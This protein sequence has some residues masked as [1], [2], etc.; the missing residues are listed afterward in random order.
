MYE[1]AH[2]RLGGDELGTFVAHSQPIG[3][4]SYR[5]RCA[6]WKLCRQNGPRGMLN[7]LQHVLAHEA[8]FVRTPLSPRFCSRL[9]FF[10]ARSRLVTVAR[11][12]LCA[13]ESRMPVPQRVVRS[14]RMHH[15]GEY[16]RHFTPSGAM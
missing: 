14:V 16:K 11:T 7:V 12:A 3:A 15:F 10:R 13:D 1:V 2:R 8:I 5:V 4:V 9:T 6:M